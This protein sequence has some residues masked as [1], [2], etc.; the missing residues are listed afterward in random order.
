MAPSHVTLQTYDVWPLVEAGAVGAPN[1]QVLVP[2]RSKPLSGK[3]G[4]WPAVC[5]RVT[6]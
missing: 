1:M 2:S 4:L 5:F 3:Y 6:P